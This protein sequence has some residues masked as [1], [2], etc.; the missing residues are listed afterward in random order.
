M[1]E[2]I[3]AKEIEENRD[4]YIQFLRDLIKINTCNPPGNEKLIALKIQDYLQEGSIKSE[5]C[6]FDENRANLIASLH[7][8]FENKNLLYNGHMDT[9]PIGSESEWE[10]S[11]FS[12]NIKNNNEIIGRGTVDMKSG[13]AAM[14]IALKI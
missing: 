3:I 4:G 5:I 6:E 1:N 13:L 7:D 8:N 2:S 14:V 9:V 11:P 10:D 12:A